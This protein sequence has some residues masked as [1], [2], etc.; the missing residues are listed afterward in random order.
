MKKYFKFKLQLY[1]K[2]RKL[3]TLNLFMPAH[4]D[5]RNNPEE[6]HS[7]ISVS[8]KVGKKPLRNSIKSQISKFQSRILKYV[9]WYKLGLYKQNNIH[10]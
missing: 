7:H 2:R 5:D 9:D 10:L 4:P 8:V 6:K 3:V 1:Y